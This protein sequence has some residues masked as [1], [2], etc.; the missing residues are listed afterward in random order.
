MRCARSGVRAGDRVV[1][2]MPLV[3]E[4]IVAMFAC[5]RIGAVHSVVFGGFSAL[6]LRERIEDAGARVLLTA[7][8]GYRAGNIVEL[9]A[10][11][12]EALAQGCASIEKVIVL[13][14]TG[15]DVPMQSGRDIWWHEAVVGQSPRVR[16]GVGGRGASAVPAV[17][18]RLDRPAQG[19]PAFQR[20]LPARRE[21]HDALGARCARG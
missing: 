2:Y 17:H 18:L 15:A 7:D 11:A 20:R 4:I 16:P 8:G 21:A 14:R 19:H 9:K 6:S 12:D 1:I 13:R 10:A 3:P 5:A